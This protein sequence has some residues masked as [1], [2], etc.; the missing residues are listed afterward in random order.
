MLRAILSKELL[1]HLQSLRFAVGFVLIV[2]LFAAGSGVWNI[3]YREEVEK[4]RDGVEELEKTLKLTGRSGIMEFTMM[5][6]TLHLPPS[7]AGFMSGGYSH[8]LPNAVNVN[9]SQ[10]QKFEQQADRNPLLFRRDLDWTFAIGLL[11]TLLALLVTYD[12]V[13]G[14]KERGSLRQLMANQVPRDL[15]LWSKYLA[16]MIILS[17]PLLAGGVVSLLVVSLGGSI[18]IP[19]GIGLPL[20]GVAFSGL[21]CISSFVWLALFVSS[22]TAN[23]S[24]A[25]L[26]LLMVW[27]VLVV[28][29]SNSGGLIGN[30]L[31]PVPRASDMQR[32]IEEIWR[33]TRNGQ[34]QE[35]ALRAV[36]SEYWRQLVRQIEVAQQIT[37]YSPVSAFRYLS[38]AICSTGISRFRLF[39]DQADRYRQ[40]LF[41][42]VEREDAKDPESSHKLV[43]GHQGTISAKR[44]EHMDEIPRFRFRE[45]QLGTRLQ[46]GTQSIVILLL[47]NLVFAT[48]AFW[49]FRRYDVR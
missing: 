48:G 12:A 1:E 49:S 31:A 5:I 2:T 40:E 23:S 4:Y 36:R 13:A 24:F 19:D 11:G 7:P 16:S 44:V 39:A 37:Q 27:A 28:F 10:V 35:A 34:E 6:A 15:V 22:R 47:Y 43:P 17:V 42:F 41:E 26:V 20:V 25:L 45:D 8:G 18:G 30:R 21:L 9:A 32:Q 29:V 38:E 33:T 14:E 3:R 46:L